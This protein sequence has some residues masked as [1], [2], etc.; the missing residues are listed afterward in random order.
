MNAYIYCAILSSVFLVITLYYV[1][2]RKL[3]FQYCIFWII[4]DIILII[5][6]V[7]KNMVESAA[8]SVGIYY[9]PALLFVT[10]IV[11]IFFLIFYITIVISDFKRRITRLTQE[12]AILKNEL[13]EKEHGSI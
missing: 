6:S 3:E 13:E 2:K 1:K 9:A 10:G 12:V 8:K 11:F 7:N 5:L 4:I